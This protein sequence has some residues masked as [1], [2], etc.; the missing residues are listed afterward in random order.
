MNTV[1]QSLKQ[2]LESEGNAYAR[3][4][5]ILEAEQNALV[6]WSIADLKEIEEKKED[7]LAK[8]QNLERRRH[9]FLQSIRKDLDRLGLPL[10]VDQENIRL[11]DIIVLLD[12][13]DASRLRNLQEKLA[14]T[15]RNVKDANYKNQVLLRRSMEIVNANLNIYV[16]SEKLAETY[17]ANGKLSSQR[18]KHLVNGSI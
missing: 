11:T 6:N 2:H 14:S 15:V 12:Q 5:S 4:R 3:L 16:Q 10:S 17:N 18:D 7:A 13:Q 8:I 9:R 1:A